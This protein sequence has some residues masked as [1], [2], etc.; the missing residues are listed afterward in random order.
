[1]FDESSIW[2]WEQRSWWQKTDKFMRCS[3][4][5]RKESSSTDDIIYGRTLTFEGRWWWKLLFLGNVVSQRNSL[6]AVMVKPGPNDVGSKRST[7]SRLSSRPLNFS[8]WAAKHDRMRAFAVRLTT[9]HRNRAHPIEGQNRRFNQ[10]S[11]SNS[12]KINCGQG[13]SSETEVI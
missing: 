2:L 7:T 4:L 5:L 9:C 8:A 12:I 3:C 1:M 10:L 11:T 6:Q 13:R